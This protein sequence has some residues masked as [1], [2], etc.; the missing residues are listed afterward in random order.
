MASESDRTPSAAY[1]VREAKAL[2]EVGV[3]HHGWY[4]TEAEHR[5]VL[6]VIQ[7]LE[8]ALEELLDVSERIRGGD[9]KLNPEAWYAARDYAKVVLADAK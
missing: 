2:H 8:S 3:A 6:D 4:M 7:R 9:P 5:G 1:T